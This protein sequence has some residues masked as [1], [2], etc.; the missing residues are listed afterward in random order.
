MY[1]LYASNKGLNLSKTVNS[2]GKFLYKKLDGSYSMKK[3][4]NTCEVKSTVLYQIPK[5]VSD[6][7]NLSKE[8]RDN[9]QVMDVL[10]SVT[11]YSDKIRVEVVELSPEEKTIGFKT[12]GSKWFE[13]MQDGLSEVW[14]FVTSSIEKEFEGYDVLF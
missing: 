5:E 14:F 13:N 10:I 11:T 1:Y 2:V 9:V 4:S 12:L 6:K 7:Y 8:E 3:R